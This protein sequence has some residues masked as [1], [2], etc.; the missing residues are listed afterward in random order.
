MFF[1]RF[2]LDPALEHTVELQVD[3]Q[4]IE[5]YVFR[6][7]IGAPADIIAEAALGTGIAADGRVEERGHDISR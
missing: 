4:P 3:L 7:G 5:R 6:V 1:P 2:A